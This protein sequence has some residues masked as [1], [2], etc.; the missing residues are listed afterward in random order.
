ML[1]RLAKEHYYS[2]NLADR[3]FK[4]TCI[5]IRNFFKDQNTIKRTSRNRTLLVFK[6]LLTIMLTK[7][8]I[9]A[10]NCLL[11][12]SWYNNI[13]FIPNF[14]Q[15]Y[16]LLNKLLLLIKKCLCAVLLS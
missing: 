13:V 3:L 9:S 5:H 8:F 16:F 6:K 4:N 7:E 1:K 15:T 14:K 2:N 11:T 10:F 12:S